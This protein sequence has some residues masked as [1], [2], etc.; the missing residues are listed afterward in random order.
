MRPDPPL[1][2]TRLSK[3][4]IDTADKDWNQKRLTNLKE[5]Q[6]GAALGDVT[7]RNGTEIINLVPGVSGNI[8]TTQARTAPPTWTAPPD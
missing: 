4:V 6:T 1:V 3:V 7:V 5:M 8:L 2:D